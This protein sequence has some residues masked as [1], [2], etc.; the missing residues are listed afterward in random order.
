MKTKVQ[1]TEIEREPRCR[2]VTTYTYRNGPMTVPSE[3][4]TRSEALALFDALVA[5]NQYRPETHRRV[6]VLTSAECERWGYR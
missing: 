4:R 3:P 6:R 5:S 1:K 2:V